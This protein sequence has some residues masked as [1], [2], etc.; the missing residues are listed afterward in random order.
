METPPICVQTVAADVQRETDS[1][2][3]RFLDWFPHD[4]TCIKPQRKNPPTSS[5]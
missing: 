5:N 4:S 3:V 1:E 2:A